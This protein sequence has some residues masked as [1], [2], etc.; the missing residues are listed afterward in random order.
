MRGRLTADCEVFL[1]GH[2]VVVLREKCKHFSRVAALVAGALLRWLR[3]G[4]AAKP[5]L[6]RRVD[7]R[8]TT[9]S[10]STWKTEALVGRGLGLGATRCRSRR[11]SRERLRSKHEVLRGG[12]HTPRDPELV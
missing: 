1:F 2:L 7:V 5:R 8:L 10:R 12:A 6:G 9:Y 4:G 3:C 11:S